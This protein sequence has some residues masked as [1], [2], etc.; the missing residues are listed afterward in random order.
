LHSRWKPQVDGSLSPDREAMQLY[1]TQQYCSRGVLSQFLDDQ[2]NWQWCMTGEEVC[3]VCREPHAKSRP[4]HKA[5]S[6][7]TQI[8]VQIR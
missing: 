2:P 5:G 8:G 4:L 1:L 7:L 3:Q 6:D